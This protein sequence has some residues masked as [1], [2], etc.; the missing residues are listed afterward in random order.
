MRNRTAT[1]TQFPE[2]IELN[3]EFVALVRDPIVDVWNAIGSDWLE[4]D[5]EGEAALEGVLDADRL[6]SFGGAN[7]KATQEFLRR[8]YDRF[9]YA[10]V[11][12]FLDKKLRLA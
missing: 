3:D 8:M 11:Y 12:D 10:K 7:G 2:T 4:I 6:E 5:P 9:G 1:I